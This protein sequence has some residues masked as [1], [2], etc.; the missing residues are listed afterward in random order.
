MRVFVAAVLALVL[1]LSIP[2]AASPAHA[3]SPPS[4]TIDCDSN[5]DLSA[6]LDVLPDTSVRNVGTA[7]S[8]VWVIG[9]LTTTDAITFFNGASEGTCAFD[10]G[11]GLESVNPIAKTETSIFQVLASGTFTITP[12]GVSPTAV[13]IYLDAC[14]LVGSGISQD[15]WRVGSQTDFREIGNTTAPQSCVLSGHYLQTSDIILDHYADDR[16]GGTFSGVYD[17]DHYQL[18]LTGTGSEGWSYDSNGADTPGGFSERVGLFAIVTGTIQKVRLTGALNTSLP[19]AGGLAQIL[20]GGGVISEVESTVTLR[21]D[22]SNN[23]GAFGGIVGQLG[24]DGATAP[25][26]IQYSKYQGTIY[27]EGND[28]GGSIGIGGIAGV[29]RRSDSTGTVVSEIRDSYSRVTVNYM[30]VQDS[31]NFNAGGLVGQVVGK[32][33]LLVR[34]Y[35]VPSFVQTNPGFIP[36]ANPVYLGGLIGHGASSVTASFSVLSNF[37]VPGPAVAVG[38]ARPGDAPVDYT[39]PGLLPV[40]VSVDSTELQTLSTYT[41]K[42]FLP[43]G[44]GNPGGEEILIGDGADNDYRWAITSERSTFVPSSYSDV[45][46]YTSRQLWPDPETNRKFYQTLRAGVLTTDAHGGS[47]PISTITYTT[48]GN[49]WEICPG[50]DFPTLVWEEETCGTGGGGSGSGSADREDPDHSNPGG[51]SDEEYLAFLASGLTLEQW[52]ATRLATTGSSEKAL[53]FG[54]LFGGVLSLVGLGMAIVARRSM[55]GKVSQPAR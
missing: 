36:G 51:L 38:F 4:M 50:E 14:S 41:T 2:Y 10:K 23:N 28:L 18:N 35:S 12:E 39:D 47:D 21:T 8:P 48:L 22:I 5:E 54:F 33:L 15:P 44:S 55:R 7:L 17:G 9:G 25:V 3:A 37:W 49:V 32:N 11:T 20:D 26:R 24:T 31:R 30:R 19:I 29:S 53:S 45:A 6:S 40:A 42:E 1:G 16:V 13:T 34:N 43:A 52:Q 27:W 46:D